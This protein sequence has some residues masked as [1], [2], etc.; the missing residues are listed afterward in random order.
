MAQVLPVQFK[1]LLQLRSLGVKADNITFRNVTME[2]YTKIVVRDE[3]EILIVDTEKQNVTKLPVKVESAIMNP[4]SNVLGL[5][6]ASVKLQ[7]YNLDMKARIMDTQMD[8]AVVF[9]RWIN[10][11]T[12]G[13][14]TQKAVFHWAMGQQKPVKIF[15]RP[16]D[17]RQI[18]IIGYDVSKDQKWCFLQGLTKGDSGLEGALQLYSVDHKKFQPT[19]NAHGACFASVKLDNRE[20]E[21]NIFSFTM[22]KPTQLCIMELGNPPNVAGHKLQTQFQVKAEGDFLVTMTPDLKHGLLFGLTKAGYLYLFDIHSGKEV[23]ARQVSQQ[24]MFLTSSHDET[25]GVVTLDRNGRVRLFRVD[26][27]NLVPFITKEMK[28]YDLGVRTAHRYNLP[29]AGDVFQN[30]FESLMAAQKYQDAAKLAAEAPQGVLRTVETIQRFK[31]VQVP[32]GQPFPDLRYFQ[33]LLK[34]GSLNKMESIGLCERVL[35]LSADT[36][37]AHCE[38]WIQQGKLE[39]SED[40]G[41]LMI[42][43]D[44]KLACSIYLRAGIP[45]KT[46]LCFLRM[47]HQDKIVDYAKS[48]KYT[49][50]YPDLLRMLHQA[51]RDQAKDFAVR[52]VEQNNIAVDDVMNIFMAGNDVETT[53]AFLL[54]HLKERGDRDEDAG[55]QTKLLEINLR[56]M[57]Q[58]ADAILESDDI[59]ISKYDHAHI[60]R[61]CENA[62]LF[63]RALEH[64][65]DLEDIKRVL[66]MG[67]GTNSLHPDF[68]LKFFGDLRPE[69]ALDCLRDLLHYGA[70][71]LLLVVEVAKRYSDQ[72]TPPALIKM[73]EEFD[74]SQGLYLYLGSFVNYTED[75]SLILKYIEAA[76]NVGQI[77]Q[78]EHVCRENNHYDPAAVKSFLLETNKVKDP[79]P[80]IHVCDRHG[81]VPELTQYLYTNQMYKFIEVY[82]QKMNPAATPKVV[83]ALLDLNAPEDQIRTLVNSVR[84]PQCP[85]K[86]LVE[87]VEKRVRLSLLLQWLENR[88]H[89][90]LEDT[91]LH[92]ALGKIYVDINNNPQH[93]LQTNKFYDSKEVGAYCESRD[94]LLAFLAYKR[95]DGSCDD[96]LVA[97]TNKHGFYKDQARYLVERMDEGLWEKVLSAENEHRRSV[98]DQ[99][100]ATALPESRNPDEISLAV[101][102]FMAAELPNELIE[103]LERIV[104]SGASDRTFRD[105][106]SLQN[107]LILTAIKAD[108][109]RVAGYIDRLDNYDGPDIAKIAVSDQYKLYEEGFLIYKKFTKGKEAISVLLDLIQDMDRAA[110]FAIYLDEQ[111]VWGLLGKAQLDTKDLTSAI[112]SFLKADDAQHY[113]QVIAD[114]NVSQEFE[115]L[116]K[117]LIMARV[118]VRDR[119]VDNELIYAYAK[120]NNIAAME[121]F[122]SVP[123]HAKIDE[124]GDRCYQEELYNSARILFSSISNYAKLASALVKLEKFQDSVDAA[125]KANSIQTWKDVCYACVEAGM[126]R[127]AQMCGVNIIVFM[128]HLND[129]IKHYESGGH[130][131]ELIALLEQ[132]INLDRAHQGIYTQLGMLYCKYKEQKLMEHINLFWSRL[133]IPTL[134]Q[135]CKD[136]LHWKE[137]VFLYTH[138]DQF[139][140]AIDIVIQHHPSC[141]DHEQFKSH[142]VRVSNTEVYYRAINFYLCNHPLQLTELL[143]E[144]ATKLDHKRVVSMVRQRGQLPLIQRYLKHVQNNDIAMI[145]EALNELY[146]EEEDYTSLRDSIDTYGTFDQISLATKMQSHELLEFRRISAYLYKMSKRWK[147][148]IELSKKDSLW[149]DAMET[150]A[151]SGD[152]ELAEEIVRFFVNNKDTPTSCFAACLYTCFPLLKPDVVLELAWRKDLQKPSMPFMIQAL[153]NYSNKVNSL[154]EKINQMEEDAVA[155]REQ[156]QKDQ[157]AAAANAANDIYSNQL[158]LTSA[159]NPPGVQSYGMPQGYGV[160]QQPINPT[161]MSGFPSY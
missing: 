101:R 144:L 78:I 111:D 11:Q 31:N 82:V 86:E 155:A 66:Q 75:P 20:T 145:N 58:V 57:P 85:V 93:F 56:S 64:Y 92:N 6:A 8:S 29:G 19:M 52:L 32:Q 89:E 69:E 33:I 113:E 148:S 128:D 39:Y 142:I 95:A 141:W 48:V 34:K 12:V 38:K 80:L 26:E 121:S 14:V 156:E 2:H 107:L 150:A 160:M 44:Q 114:A 42:R 122:I 40:L 3:N 143:N 24:A 139:D 67:T 140:N 110:E 13:I 65:E 135:A 159:S 126:F 127:L 83:G 120:T 98:I 25:G 134:L 54:D 27:D 108:S 53:T 130:F 146:V 94:P 10:L 30:R 47:G 119:V 99:V 41:D 123:N 79:R 1:E 49:P 17:G 81:F 112:E 96:E 77:A 15:D 9:W 87:E 147:Q 71:N 84:P 138:Y 60:A 97:I 74:K 55:L 129:L 116:I 137:T 100:V 4:A 117:Y 5:R 61:L 161:T 36:G 21:A 104:L 106:K 109:N 131:A 63:Q 18:Q 23:Y 37:K 157:E 103:L 28:D 88:L 73:F 16:Q 7:I 118:K 68:L 125:R 45:E 70:N 51:Q 124:V 133:N 50:N 76:A 72:L 158:M 59:K 153:R 102:A 46:I 149:Q 91:A 22:A 115:A 90:G 43:F 105:N 136:N 62:R 151:E 152:S 35:N 154:Q 132:G